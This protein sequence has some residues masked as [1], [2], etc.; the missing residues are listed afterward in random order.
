LPSR[1]IA[2][3]LK[4]LVPMIQSELQQGN[5]AGH[6][7]Y[8]RAGEMLIEAKEQVGHGGWGRWL[9]KNFNLSQDTARLY[10]RLARSQNV[11][12]NHETRSFSSI[13]EMRGVTERRREDYQSKQQQAFRRVL[14]DVA[15]DKTAA[16]LGIS[17]DTVRNRAGNLLN[18]S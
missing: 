6:E 1:K 15:A 2:R 7:H 17:D 14:R 10:M 9:T 12:G 18:C 13:N 11:S 8:V 5:S 3:P 16:D 4:V